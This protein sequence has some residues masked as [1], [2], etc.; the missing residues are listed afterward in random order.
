MKFL[1]KPSMKNVGQYV[2]YF[3]LFL[4]ILFI[5]SKFVNVGEMKERFGDFAPYNQPAL[6]KAKVQDNILMDMRL[7]EWEKQN[8][9]DGGYIK[10]GLPP[11]NPLYNY[12]SLS[13]HPM[14]S[15]EEEAKVVY[16]DVFDKNYRVGM[17]GNV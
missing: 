13:F 4:V 2:L 17:M 16:G 11:R 14:Q 5:V 8:S 7:Q 12:P 15:P 3:V 9:C 6:E 10:L 1:E